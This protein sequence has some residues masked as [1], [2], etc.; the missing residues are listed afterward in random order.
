MPS[1]VARPNQGR[2]PQPPGKAP[3]VQRAAPRASRRLPQWR[4]AGTACLIVTITVLAYLP[5]L[6]GGYVWDDD[7]Y[8][9]QN[10]TLRSADGLR[11]IWFEP[12]ST[13]Q[14]YPLA[15]TAFWIEYRLWG[16][17]PRGFHAVNIAVHAVNALLVWLLLRRLRVPGALVA[18]AI[19][20][21][22]PVHVDTVAW[23]AERKSLLS[24]AFCLLTLLAWLRF[25]ETRRWDA[26]ALVLLLFSGA[27]LSKTAAC[28]LPLIL[29]LVAWWQKPATGFRD[30]PWLLPLLVIAVP[31]G[32]ITGWRESLYGNPS[33][34]IPYVQRVLIAGRA[35]W[36]YAWKL[37]WPANL[38]A[39]YPQWHIDAGAVWQ[40]LFP[41]AVVACLASL[42][43]W[44]ERLGRGPLVACKAFVITLAPTLGF[45]EFGFLN[46]AYVAD[47]FQYLAS[48][49][50]IAVLGAAATMLGQR[51][52]GAPRWAGPAL[53]GVLLVV[54]G[55]RTWQQAGLY[56]DAE[57]L[58]RDNFARN[59]D[60]WVVRNYLGKALMDQGK[61]D[62]AIPQFAAAV[63]LKPNYVDA[64]SYWA[65]ALERQGK[66]DEAARHYA[67]ALSA[68]Q[69]RRLAYAH[70]SLGRVLAAQGKLDEAIAH[71][72]VAAQLNPHDA[73]VDNGWGMALDQQG[74]LDEARQ[75]YMAALRED[76]LNV[77][78]HNNL[79]AL[80]G[81]QGQFDAAREHFA[82][83][84]RI[85]PDDAHVR[86]N[87]GLLL[88]KQGKL[89][90]ARQQF[91]DAVRVN[92][93]QAEAH[94][95]LGM[96]LMMQGKS[97][98]AVPHFVEAVR[99]KPD[100]AEAQINLQK[101]RA[102]APA[103][104]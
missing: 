8:L 40:Y 49:S 100:Y 41:L 18:A 76:P 92:P 31:L 88:A 94:N 1:K 99:L 104:R 82:A 77:D 51:V 86:L 19:F 5:A 46:V 24:G 63:H 62:E 90:E 14:Y 35:V 69:P 50:L 70:S 25:L 42:W 38:M 93:A 20:A 84:L 91:V 66:L 13:P 11:Q 85:K 54:L 58:W 33:M 43:L 29:L 67:V 26:Y 64:H 10:L 60:S 59:P 75:H 2:R 57:T 80:L 72:A 98:E 45:V 22:H 87:L 47:H 81:R 21:V 34:T 55:A 78:A 3:A 83:A 39:V 56:K 101:A 79:G 4:A 74:K 103:P 68:T 95:F 52:L 73:D 30:V 53:A 61:L 16:L 12:A 6:R 15:F 96:V 65:F 28:T 27:M 7:T 48:I 23:I 37:V 102:R 89:D 36:F 32:L 97:D 44:R 9:A 71:F 17:T